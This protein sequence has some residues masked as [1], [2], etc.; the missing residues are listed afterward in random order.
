LRL[1][2]R[3]ILRT[4]TLAAISPIFGQVILSPTPAGAQTSEPQWRHGVSLF[5]D[6]KYSSGFKHF[7][8]VNPKAPKGG[9]LRL[10]ALGSFDNFNQAIAG[11]KGLF[12]AAAGTICDTLLVSS[13]DEPLAQYGLIAEAV[14]YPAN[15]A[16]TTFRLREAAHHHDGNPIT[17]EDVIYSFQAYKKY[18]PFI[19]A[20]FRDVVKVEQS[21]EREVTFTFEAAGNREIPAILDNSEYYQSTGGKETTRRARSA[22]SAQPRSSRRSAMPPTGSR[23]SFPAAPWFTSV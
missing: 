22:I 2:R 13:F 1:T 8:Y 15:F 10:M 20:F 14:S 6:P 17:V 18:N 21:G 9:A 19:G 4:G 5:G 16:S 7:V 3:S 11:L 23:N 12:A